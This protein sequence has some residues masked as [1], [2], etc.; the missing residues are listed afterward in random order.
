MS[1]K[2]IDNVDMDSLM[3]LRNEYA[4]TTNTLGLMSADEYAIN[5]QLKQLEQEKNKMF[6]Q[7]DQLRKNEMDLMDSLKEKY[8]DGQINL[9]DG[10]FTSI[11]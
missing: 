11:S 2:K 6:E 7:L 4:D 10:T 3:K 1:T 8:G 9:E 5:Q